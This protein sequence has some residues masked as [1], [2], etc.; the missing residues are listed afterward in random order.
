MELKPLNE[1]LNESLE[2]KINYVKNNLSR[3]I[4][5]EQRE[6]YDN[7]RPLIEVHKSIFNRYY[8]R[9][10]G[11]L[12]ELRSAIRHRMGRTH[13]LGEL[14]DGWY[15]SINLDHRLALRNEIGLSEKIFCVGKIVGFGRNHIVDGCIIKYTSRAIRKKSP[16]HEAN[17]L[18]DYL[19][20]KEYDIS[21]TQK[22]RAIK[23]ISRICDLK[24]FYMSLIIGA[25]EKVESI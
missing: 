21:I 25:Q 10:R 20:T 16:S 5:K 23:E 4:N 19:G 7:Y 14:A 15:Y 11:E 18:E 1:I 2:E 8:E 22:K 24:E 9:P 12:S 6:G 3:M 13:C 17:A